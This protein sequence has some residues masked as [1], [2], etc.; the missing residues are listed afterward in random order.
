[1]LMQR[2]EAQALR[3]GG[4]SSFSW[5]VEFMYEDLLLSEIDYGITWL[6]VHQK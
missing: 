5:T 6:P 1:M 4:I 3:A 2:L